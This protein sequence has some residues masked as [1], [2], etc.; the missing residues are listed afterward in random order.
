MYNFPIVFALFFLIIAFNEFLFYAAFRQFLIKLNNSGYLVKLLKVLEIIILFLFVSSGYLR[1][2]FPNFSY[3]PLIYNI[4]CCL[5]LPKLFFFPVF[6]FINFVHIIKRIIY[7]LRNKKVVQTFSGDRRK[8]LSSLAWGSVSLPI[9]AAGQGLAYGIF[10]IKKRHY[11]I[12][13]L[14]F[15]QELDGFRIVH[16][17]DLHFGSFSSIEAF[18]KLCDIINLELEPDLIFITGDFVNYNIDEIKPYLKLLG[19]LEARYKKFAVMGNHDIY[20]GEDEL[21]EILISLNI[22]VLRNSSFV[23]NTPTGYVQI[24]G[25]DFSKDALVNQKNLALAFADVDEKYPCF[26]L[27]HTPEVWDKFVV[28][29][30]PADMTFAGHTHGGQVAIPFMKRQ[31]FPWKQV[32]DTDKIYGLFNKYYQYL[33]VTSGFGTTMLNVRIGIMPEVATFDIKRVQDIV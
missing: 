8:L 9:V 29:K 10:D 28:D 5:T 20:A 1:L 2:V 26:L 3:F 30:Y 4:V 25:V 16:I 6:L 17:S 19:N 7:K 14:D 27:C 12:P 18:R 32:F 23:L 13:L 15:P 24:V 22:N 21:T 33:Y 31:F 11:E